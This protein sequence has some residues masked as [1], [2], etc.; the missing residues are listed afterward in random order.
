MLRDLGEGR[1][2]DLDAHGIAMQLL[3]RL[4]TQQLPADVAVE[5]LPKRQRR[6]DEHTAVTQATTRPH[7]A[8]RTGTGADESIPAG[9]R[10]GCRAP[11]AQPP[12]LLAVADAAD[13]GD[14]LGSKED[15]RA[16]CQVSIGTFQAGVAGAVAWARTIAALRAAAP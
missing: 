12:Q 2:A 8:P 6:H 4:T 3:S 15:L 16:R 7:C 9:P 11:R 14:R 10:P 5:E 1:L 13:A